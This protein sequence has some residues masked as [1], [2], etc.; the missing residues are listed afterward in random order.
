MIPVRVAA[1]K[2]TNAAVYLNF[3]SGFYR[4]S[5]KNYSKNHS[6][7]VWLFEIMEF[8]LTCSPFQ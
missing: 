8:Q 3:I 6:Q 5:Y 1:V 7:E 2:N 4:I